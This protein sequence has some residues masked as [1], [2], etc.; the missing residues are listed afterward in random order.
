[1][2][3]TTQ[4][5]AKNHQNLAINLRLNW[6]TASKE[7]ADWVRLFYLKSLLFHDIDRSRDCEFS[8]ESK[9]DS[10]IV[11]KECGWNSA[12]PNP[13]SRNCVR[14]CENWDNGRATVTS[15]KECGFSMICV[16]Q[17][18]GLIKILLMHL[19]ILHRRSTGAPSVKSKLPFRNS[20]PKITRPLCKIVP[21]SR[22]DAI[23]MQERLSR[24]A[25]WQL[26]ASNFT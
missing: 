15:A 12:V 18:K 1:M 5:I 24:A 11:D 16:R 17:S 3:E 7:C 6:H 13:I 21:Y 10:E 22:C 2:S 14:Y 9:E 19:N 25:I 8:R 4:A 20:M 23:N 26:V